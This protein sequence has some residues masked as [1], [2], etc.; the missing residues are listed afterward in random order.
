LLYAPQVN[1]DDEIT[2]GFN[3]IPKPIKKKRAKN[4]NNKNSSDSRLL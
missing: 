1:E 4:I 3:V 2:I